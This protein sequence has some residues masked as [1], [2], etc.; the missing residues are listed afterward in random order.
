MTRTPRPEK[1]DLPQGQDAY[2]RIITEIRAGKLRPGDRLTETDLAARFGI[3]RTPVRE[4]IRQLESD[5]LVSH[6]PRVGA[7]IRKLDYAEISELY[8]MRTVLEGTAAR[9]AARAASAVELEELEDLNAHLAQVGSGRQAFE[10]NAQ[11]HQAVLHAARNRFLIKSVSAINTTMLILG[12]STLLEEE[13]A[14][15]AVREHQELITALRA[16]DEQA[17]ERIMQRHIEGGQRARLRL[18]RGID[19]ST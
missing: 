11:F 13:R 16:R 2:R 6:V 8:D 7:T 4:A 5:G 12:P 14:G 18:L 19:L 9:F 10:L 1:S 17:A 15:A 3:S